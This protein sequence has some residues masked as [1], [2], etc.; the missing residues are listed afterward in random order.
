MSKGPENTFIGSIHRYLPVEI[1]HMKNNNQ[2]NSGIADCWYSGNACDLW[3]EYK[4]V[5]LPKRPTTLIDLR[6][7]N[8]YLTALQQKWLEDRFNEGRNVGV[9]AGC[10]AGGVVFP[11][12]LW[13]SPIQTSAFVEKA[14]PRKSVADW[15]AAQTHG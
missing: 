10:K 13:Q 4:F 7:T 15:I 12:L 11:G 9:I 1:Y 6:D 3:I 14:Q 8:K 5:E 2:Y